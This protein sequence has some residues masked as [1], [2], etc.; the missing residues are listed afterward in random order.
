MSLQEKDGLQLSERPNVLSMECGATIVTGQ[1]VR[2]DAE[3]E[4]RPE[5]G[6]AQTLPHL[7]A[8]RTVLVRLMKPR[9][10]QTLLNVQESVP[11]V[12]VTSV[13]QRRLVP[14]LV[15]MVTVGRDATEQIVII[16]KTDSALTARHG[17]T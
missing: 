7:T 5:A 4:L 9:Y 10:A 3:L 1:T 6:T 13:N 12:T 11:G 8:G 16:H 17:A 15:T 2:R 14:G